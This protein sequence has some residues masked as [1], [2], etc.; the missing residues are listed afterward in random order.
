MIPINN[1]SSKR[2]DVTEETMNLRDAL[3]C[4]DCDEVFGL[5]GYVCNPRCPSCGSPVFAPLSVWV[6]TWAAYE[7]SEETKKLKRRPTSA[8]KQ[9][10]ELAR[11]TPIAA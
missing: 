11:P 3:L 7:K 9:A 2:A 4:I 5:E 8:K 10:V 1:L 6:Q